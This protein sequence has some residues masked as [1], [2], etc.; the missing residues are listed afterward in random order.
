MSDEDRLIDLETRLAYQDDLLEQLNQT[1][2]RQDQRIAEL[3]RYL[4]LV[5]ERYRA[6]REQMDRLDPHE[7]AAPPHY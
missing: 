7:D 6:L 3:E 2:A 5:S 1:V 4:E